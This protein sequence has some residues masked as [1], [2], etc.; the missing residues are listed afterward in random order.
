MTRVLPDPAPARMRSGPSVASTASCCAG[1]RASRY[2]ATTSAL[3]FHGDALGEI[4]RL[5]DV[6]APFDRDVIGQEL[7]G[8]DEKD[9]PESRFG[10]GHGEQRVARLARP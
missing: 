8:H 2:P 1:L 10:V 5:V 3:L 4:A 9:R 7:E 6:A